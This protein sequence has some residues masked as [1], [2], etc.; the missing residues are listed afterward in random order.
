LSI[1]VGFLGGYTTFSTFA[2]ESVTL[3]QRGEWAFSLT[4]AIGSVLAGC[5]AVVM[6]AA[7][8]QAIVQP[9]WS[10]LFQ[11]GQ[12]TTQESIE[13]AREIPAADQ[14][15]ILGLSQYLTPEDD[16]GDLAD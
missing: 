12:F 4:Y 9:T 7:L 2:I 16:L 15:Q 1:L 3:W 5:A 10:R 14:Q 6:G 11:M 8:A 13:R